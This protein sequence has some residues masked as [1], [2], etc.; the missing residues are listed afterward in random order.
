MSPMPTPEYEEYL[1]D[2]IRE[3]RRGVSRSEDQ[4]PYRRRDAGGPAGRVAS[5]P[6]P[7][8]QLLDVPVTRPAALGPLWKAEVIADDSGKWET[9]GLCFAT[10]EE[11]E[12]YASDLAARWTAV[13]EFRVR[14]A[15]KEEADAWIEKGRRDG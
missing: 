4:T 11:A 3:Q 9:N 13:R 2:R 6:E 15:T 12:E 5:D 1:H 7:D 14:E 8:P 10:K